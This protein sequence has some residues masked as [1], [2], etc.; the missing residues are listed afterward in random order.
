MFDV[1]SLLNTL[2]TSLSL[3]GTLG[4]LALFGES[5]D[6]FFKVSLLSTLYFVVDLI[7]YFSQIKVREI[8]LSTSSCVNP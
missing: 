3:A 5:K 6:A 8:S 1:F 2:S 7:P 4:Y